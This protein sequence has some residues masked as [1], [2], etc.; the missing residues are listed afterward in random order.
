MG[1]TLPS[2]GMW[3][4][5]YLPSLIAL[6]GLCPCLRPP[7][8]D[9]LRHT[10]TSIDQYILRVLEQ[11]RVLPPPPPGRRPHF[12]W[13]GPPKTPRCSYLGFSHNAIGP[14]PNSIFLEYPYTA[15]H[16]PCPRCRYL[17]FSGNPHLLG[18]LGY[19]AGIGGADLW[20][21]TFLYKINFRH[22]IEWSTWDWIETCRYQP[23]PPHH[24]LAATYGEH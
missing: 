4:A 24:T 16:P 18:Y 8:L 13:M 12:S 10:P 9:V 23:P 17:G 1:W 6:F 2:T 7:F 22:S 19:L 14:A 21:F 3:R 20:V 5:R 15:L 11:L